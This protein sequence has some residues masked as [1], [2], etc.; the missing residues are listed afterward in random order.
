MGGSG[1]SLLDE[2]KCTYIRGKTEAVIKNFSPHYKRQYAVSFCKHIQNELEQNRDLQSQFLKTKPPSE[3][4][5][6]FYEGES[7]HFAE[8][9]KKWKDRYIV[10]KNNYAVE[11]FESKEAFQK[12]LSAKSCILPVG[13]KVLTTEEEYNLL[14]DKHF[15]DPN[16][17][18]DKENAPAFVV[19][20]K[21]FPV[22]LWQPFLRHSYFCFMDAEAQK[23][24]STA[25]NDCIRHLNHDFFKQSSFEAQA[26]LEAVQF[27][28]QEKGHY[29]SWEMITGNEVQILSN[30]VME[31]LLP[32]LQSMLLPKMKGKKNDRKRA[33]FGIIE[34]TYRLVQDHV[35]E[36]L[37]T[38]KDECKEVTK[39]LEG[40]IRSNMDQIVTSKNFLAGKI[41]GSI[42]ESI[43]KCCG[44]SIQPFL[45]SIL[46]E[47]MGPVSSGFSEVRLLFEKEVNTISESFKA[48]NDI[49]KLKENV[50]ELMRLPHHSVKMEPCYLKVNLLQEQL[51]DLKSRFKFY[52]ID[53]IIQRTQ[54][55]MQEL[56]ENAV[57]TFDQLLGLD[58]VKD[59][60]KLAASIEK[61]K[62]RVLKQYDY[63]SSTVRKKIFQ[64]ALVQITLPTL[65]RTLASTCKP[66]L[67]EYEEYIFAE[68]NSVIQVE[69][70]Y[71][72]I[73][74]Q[75]LLDETLQVI[76]EAAHLKKHNLF[77]ET[78][79]PFES[80]SSLIDLKTPSGSTQ[81]SPVRKP[82][83]SV[84][85]VL[86]A[87]IQNNEVFTPEQNTLEECHETSKPLDDEKEFSS[88]ISSIASE[89]KEKVIIPD[90]SSKQE[91]PS[92]TQ[93]ATEEQRVPQP[94]TV[95][96]A[97]VDGSTGIE[98]TA[99][100]E[101]EKLPVPGAVDEI[102]NLLTF[103]VELP[104]DIPSE[105]TKQAVHEFETLKPQ[106]SAEETGKEDRVN[107]GKCQKLSKVSFSLPAEGN[108]T[109]K[110]SI[111]E[112]G[113][114]AIHKD[115]SE[116]SGERSVCQPKAELEAVM[117]CID[118]ESCNA[119]GH[120]QPQL[121]PQT[122]QS[123]QSEVGLPSMHIVCMDRVPQLEESAES[124]ILN[125]NKEVFS[126]LHYVPFGDSCHVGQPAEDNFQEV[127][128][129]SPPSESKEVHAPSISGYPAETQESI[130]N[131]ANLTIVPVDQPV[132]PKL[133][134]GEISNLEGVVGMDNKTFNHIQGDDC[135]Q[136]DVSFPDEDY[137]NMAESEGDRWAKSDGAIDPTVD[138]TD[139]L[140]TPELKESEISNLEGVVEV[141]NKPFDHIQGDDC[142]QADVSLRDEDYVN[143]A[144]SEGDRWAKSDGAIDPTVDPTDQPVSPELKESEISTLEGV[145]EIDNKSFDHIQGDYCK[146]ADV[147]LPD[148]DYVNM[149]ESEGD[150]WE[151]SDGAIDPTVDPTD[152]PVTPELKE[153]EI[154][155][156]EALVVIDNKIFT[157]IQGDD[158][159]LAEVSLPN[160]DYVNMA[161]GEKGG[162]E[163]SKGS[164]L[165]FQSEK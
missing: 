80:V 61:V 146:Q 147:S 162:W 104:V 116:V 15:P 114:F 73:L 20:P 21:E 27:F 125:Q 91:L 115:P 6:V 113:N 95:I 120:F 126:S 117:Q 67:Q 1:S 103:T 122:G 7:L 45:V 5:V 43:Q 87:D 89:A 4:S 134:E 22:Y 164:N 17:S 142:K 139:Q 98:N 68:H 78:G 48:T 39:G 133:K 55:L 81:T 163:I 100:V 144:E 8:D 50:I 159:K 83:S 110:A 102:R 13:G 130:L 160:E 149:A 10:I 72:E 47:L 71:E 46:E 92:M 60:P 64:D 75:A 127:K 70:V 65:Q 57:Y 36:G 137:V 88:K 138:P 19:L 32:S 33:W 76:K 12:G 69:N 96:E 25:L 28:R 58:H 150:R 74:L 152:Q 59:V 40:T 30:L 42:S 111:C 82:T 156:L 109:N 52:D 141:D 135:K 101:E 94:T 23:R 79:L 123:D 77:E 41:K 155:N 49:T 128:L 53:L 86:D 153:S 62:L 38:L 161:E 106:E 3:S 143:M 151:K 93:N 31:E 154:S 132:S 158:C 9:L 105:N 24:L 121:P 118:V 44:E 37:H 140:G 112:E 84:R 148:A 16:G 85:E 97:N 14:S 157:V 63:D 124:E 136:A 35:S 18:N 129:S 66:V 56:L 119:D 54:N 108:D 131:I 99:S 11:S 165:E 145:V 90:L 34:E 2:S 29:G 26:F 107:D 51:Q